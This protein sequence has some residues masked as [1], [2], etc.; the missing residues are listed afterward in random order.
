[1]QGAPCQ[2]HVDEQHVECMICWVDGIWHAAVAAAVPVLTSMP[3]S[4]HDGG[5]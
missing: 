1:M 5:S 3:L 4:S 2:L